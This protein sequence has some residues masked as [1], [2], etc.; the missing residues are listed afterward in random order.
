MSTHLDLAL[1]ELRQ[2][3]E[4]KRDATMP[5]FAAGALIDHIAEIEAAPGG[6]RRG[7]LE[8]LLSYCEFILRVLDRD[9][10]LRG[11]GDNLRGFFKDCF[12][13]G[14]DELKAACFRVSEALKKSD[15]VYR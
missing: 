6:L 2:A 11:G 5:N 3:R 4:W 13:H 10:G 7:D 15:G 8:Q 9:A 12:E 1:S 14:Q